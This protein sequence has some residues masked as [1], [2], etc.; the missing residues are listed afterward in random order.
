MLQ[1]LSKMESRHAK[2]E[3]CSHMLQVSSA[4]SCN[5]MQLERVYPPK[6]AGA[7]QN[8]RFYVHNADWR[9]KMLKILHIP[10]ELFVLFICFFDLDGRLFLFSLLGFTNWGLDGFMALLV[11]TATKTTNIMKS[12]TLPTPHHHQVFSSSYTNLQLTDNNQQP[13]TSQMAR[14]MEGSSSNMLQGAS[15]E[16]LQL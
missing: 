14:Q 16:R 3:L 4:K 5:T 1:V 2:L 13:T 15:N 9:C 10:R 8:E 12:Q 7:M 11:F 6:V